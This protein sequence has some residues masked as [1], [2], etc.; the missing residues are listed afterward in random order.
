VNSDTKS[1]VS[2]FSV[3]EKSDDAPVKSDVDKPATERPKDLPFAPPRKLSSASPSSAAGGSK[4]FKE[5]AERWE[6]GS[7]TVASPQ[8]VFSPAAAFAARRAVPETSQ[9]PIS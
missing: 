9:V 6:K 3:G 1:K 5:L 8:S 2:R 7:S 4:S